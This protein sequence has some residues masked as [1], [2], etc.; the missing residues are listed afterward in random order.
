MSNKV[1]GTKCRLVTKQL[2][3][4]QE[5]SPLTASNKS[6][7]SSQRLTSKMGVEKLFGKKSFG[8]QVDSRCCTYAGVND[9]DLF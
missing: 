8:R 3:H 9:L 4:S 2:N 7:F 6:L 5:P 1:T